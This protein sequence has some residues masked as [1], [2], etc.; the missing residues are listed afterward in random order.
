MSTSP[1][2]TRNFFN[3]VNNLDERSLLGAFYL[4]IQTK[5]TFRILLLRVGCC[6]YFP[7][8]TE[9]FTLPTFEKIRTMKDADWEKSWVMNQLKWVTISSHK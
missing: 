8:V 2:R 9:S 6:L 7:Q 4:F 5:H 3:F 1:V